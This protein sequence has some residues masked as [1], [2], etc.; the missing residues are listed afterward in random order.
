M[1][2]QI[3]LAFFGLASTAAATYSPHQLS[4]L[5][6]L[7]PDPVSPVQARQD[8][9]NS[10]D[11]N[12][13]D[14]A[15]TTSALSILSSIPTPASDL[16]DFLATFGASASASAPS[17][18]AV[19]CSV[20][21]ALPSSL[22]APYSSYDAAASSWYGSNSEGIQGLL[23][24]CGGGELGAYVTQVVSALQ[25][26][27]AAGC[28]GTL[29]TPAATFPVPGGLNT[30]VVTGTGTTGAATAT[31]TDGSSGSGTGAGENAAPTSSV[32]LDAAPRPTGVL[33]GAIAAAGLLG[34]AMML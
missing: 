1:Y 2:T 29:S 6:S 8:N 10:D 7:H 26:Y 20:T 27:T 4:N 9:S 15:C 23:T 33:A 19:L 25:A 34:A 16:S 32:S 13:L 24:S 18:P 14:P 17:D 11:G 3:A 12:T 5:R 31:A 21:A 30:S 28:S 22:Q